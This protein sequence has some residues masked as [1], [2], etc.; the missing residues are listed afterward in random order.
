MINKALNYDLSGIIFYLL[1]HILVA[2]TKISE[3]FLE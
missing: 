2:G 1:N 3:A